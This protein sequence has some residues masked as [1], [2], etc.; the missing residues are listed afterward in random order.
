MAKKYT[1]HMMLSNSIIES[2]KF[3]DLPLSTRFLYIYLNSQADGM[4]FIANKNAIVR[5][6]GLSE[7]GNDLKALIDAG[8]IIEFKESGII[9]IKHWHAH[10]TDLRN[11]TTNCIE[12]FEQL[13]V[14]KR[15][16]EYFFKGKVPLI[17]QKPAYEPKANNND[18]DQPGDED[19]QPAE[20]LE[21]TE[22]EDAARTDQPGTASATPENISNDLIPSYEEVERYFEEQN[23]KD[24]LAKSFYDDLISKNWCDSKGNKIENWK[25]FAAWNN[26]NKKKAHE[27]NMKSYQQLKT[28]QQKP[29][30]K[31]DEFRNK[32]QEQPAGQH[33]G[34]DILE[35]S[36]EI[37]A[38][39]NGFC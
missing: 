23:F 37:F 10:N 8:Y 24:I 1:K 2:D 3:L 21:A 33:G 27:E 39:H 26:N 20:E 12:E 13:E 18:D 30:P 38:D 5:A 15:T 29:A 32:S 34:Y 28:S 19:L 22:A 7:E 11:K 16:G 14:G 36:E 9:C 4:G 17:E 25:S 6:L 35:D 31:I